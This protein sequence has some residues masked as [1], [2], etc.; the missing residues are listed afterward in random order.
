MDL[1]EEPEKAAFPSFAFKIAAWFWKENSFVIESNKPAMKKS[2]NTLVDG[3]FLNFVLLTHSLTNNANNSIQRFELNEK[4]LKLLNYPGLK[5]GQGIECEIN[6]GGQAEKGHA[7]PICLSNFKR[8][9]CGCS[10]YFDASSCPYG[11]MTNQKCRSSEMIKCCTEQCKT[12]TD[13]LVI[14]DSASSNLFENENLELEKDFVKKLI[15][16]LDLG[17]DETRLSIV[18]SY[19]KPKVLVHFNNFTV[20][21]QQLN[22]L[23]N[24]VENIGDT[25]KTVDALRLA[26]EVLDEKYGMRPEDTGVPKVILLL[27]DGL[28]D[29]YPGVLNE[30]K[31]IK[32]RGFNIIA[33][34]VGQLDFLQELQ[35]L[36]SSKSDFFLVSQLEQIFKVVSKF[37]LKICLQPTALLATVPHKSTV[38][39]SSYRFFKVLLN[40]NN[41]TNSDL[42]SNNKLSI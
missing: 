10:G 26:N 30:A 12:A 32:A 23:V 27:T 5:K 24:D 4:I 8:S 9:Y 33:V 19:I 22:S 11:L 21:K 14:M 28:S 40:Q 16:T 3:T 13:L 34:A 2:L 31:K 35:D 25:S 6:N 29:D 42:S 39:K 41:K 7:M 15:A 17:K 36:P 1:V 37:T 18:V 38:E 20:N